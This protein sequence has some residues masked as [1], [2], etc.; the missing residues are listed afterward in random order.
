MYSVQFPA[1]KTM[2]MVMTTTG[3]IAYASANNTPAND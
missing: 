3:D 2:D 1:S